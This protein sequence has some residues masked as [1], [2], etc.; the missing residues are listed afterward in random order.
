MHCS[1]ALPCFCY[2]VLPCGLP[3]SRSLCPAATVN[4][5]AGRIEVVGPGSRAGGY[6]PF[7]TCSKLLQMAD[8]YLRN[9][10]TTQLENRE[11]FLSHLRTA[12]VAPKRHQAV[13]A[14][15]A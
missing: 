13:I 12:H 8:D 6:D 2:F 11:H 3:V 9:E 14:A 10:R 15:T 1:E 7:P 5:A 4:L